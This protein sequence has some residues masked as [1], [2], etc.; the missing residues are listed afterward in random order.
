MNYLLIFTNNT[1]SNNVY[2]YQSRKKIVTMDDSSRTVVISLIYQ[3]VD[4]EDIANYRLISC[5][6]LDNKI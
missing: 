6:N 3:K 2:V 4:E 1:L 5:L